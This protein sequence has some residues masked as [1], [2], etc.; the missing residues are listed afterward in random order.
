M[1]K[2]SSIDYFIVRQGKVVGRFLNCRGNGLLGKRAMKVLDAK[3][4]TTWDL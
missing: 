4:F 2:G 3:C 1:D